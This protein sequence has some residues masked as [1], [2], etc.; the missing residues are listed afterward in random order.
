MCRSVILFVA[1]ACTAA[2]ADEPSAL[3]QY[4][5]GAFGSNGMYYPQAGRMLAKP[6]GGFL[7][8]HG[9]GYIDTTTGRYIKRIGS[10]DEGPSL[11]VRVKV[12]INKE[13]R[14]SIR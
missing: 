6:Q 3:F 5:H 1:L 7:R 13:I 8:E 2:A 12:D 11:P 4:R 9:H 14:E 10:R